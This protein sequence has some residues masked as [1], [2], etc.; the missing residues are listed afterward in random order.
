MNKNTLSPKF[1]VYSFKKRLLW[2][3]KHKGYTKKVEEA[4]QYSAEELADIL[5]NQNLNYDRPELSVLVVSPALLRS[6]EEEDAMES[7]LK[8]DHEIRRELQHEHFGLE[9]LNDYLNPDVP[10]FEV[11]HADALVVSSV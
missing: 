3:P 1:H 10:Y 9:S 6:E 8:F 2:K 11:V 5:S 7:T 4:G